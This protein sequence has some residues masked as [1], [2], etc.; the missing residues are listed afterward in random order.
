[1]ALP[2]Y[3]E[4]TAKDYAKQA[5]ATY[6]APIETSTFTGGLD[7]AGV[8]AAGPGITGINPYVAQMDPLQTDAITMAQQ[9]VGSYKPYLQ[10]AQTGLGTAGTD[11]AAAR[12]A[13]GG[14]GALTGAAAYQPFMSPYQQD[15]I[16]TSLTEFDRQAQMQQQQLRD[17]ALGTAGAFGGG[18]EG[19]QQAEY[20]AGSDRNRQMLHAG[21]L[22]QGYGNAQTA[23]QQA[24]QNQQ[25]IAQGQLGLGQAQMGLGREQMGLSNFERTGLGG[26]IGAY[27]QLGA[28]RQGQ[29]QANLTAN[30]MAAQ[31]AAYEPYGR[32]NQYG[33][34]ITGLAGGVAGMQYNQPQQSNPWASA[35]GTALG[36]GGMFG[37]IYGQKL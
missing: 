32:L 36:V 33:Q 20:Q 9:G 35:L 31:T 15:V 4:D 29:E 24:F 37:K 23:A 17:Q 19:V 5:T 18:R 6:K 13:A 2:G 3:L 16:D 25:A 7:A 28:M 14:L 26:D 1:M 12:T 30:Q 34:G 10:A 27:G 11:V 21:M 8:R 22:Q